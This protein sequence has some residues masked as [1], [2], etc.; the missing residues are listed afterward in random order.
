M[1]ST[2]AMTDPSRANRSRGTV[3]GVFAILLWATSVAGS[4]VFLEGFGLL[5]GLAILFLVAGTSLVGTATLQ[6][7]GFAWVRRVSKRHVVVAG[8]FYVAYMLSAYSAF[9]LAATRADAIVAGL[10][11]YLW[12]SMILLFSIVILGTRPRRTLLFVGIASAVLG[13]ALASS[14]SVGGISALIPALASPSLST[15]LGL[16]AAVV[17]GLYSVLARRL[18]QPE[19]CGAIGLFLL[20][21]GVLMSIVSGRAWGQ[22]IWAWKPTVS[23]LYMALLPNALAYWAWETGVR[24]GDIVALGALS[25]VTPILSALIAAVFLGVGMRLELLM[26]ALLVVLGSF[27]A[28][29]AFPASER[30]KEAG[31]ADTVSAEGGSR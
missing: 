8:P 27:L 12:P 31:R 4:R 19:P 21:A 25:N 3:L 7:R 22:I 26:G 28:W 6:S 30:R 16:T 29:W 2:A 23:L 11:N 15:G 18:K 10:A 20:F 13:I 24:D 9:G 14:S 5:V 1:F 17:F